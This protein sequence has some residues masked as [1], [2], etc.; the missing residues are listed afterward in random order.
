MR[1]SCH[2]CYLH[3]MVVDEKNATFY[4]RFTDEVSLVVYS[5]ENH[6]PEYYKTDGIIL[7][8]VFILR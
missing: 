1:N 4:G 3:G 5:A 2:E 6:A 8:I 7:S